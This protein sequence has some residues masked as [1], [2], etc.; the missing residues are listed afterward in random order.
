MRR[1][2]APLGAVMLTVV[3]GLVW[4]AT[5]AS[6]R[7]WGRVCGGRMRLGGLALCGRR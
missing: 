6:A 1:R 3:A 5:T 4:S 7:Y 2:I